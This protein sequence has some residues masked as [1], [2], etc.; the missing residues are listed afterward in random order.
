MTTRNTILA[1]ALMVTGGLLGTSLLRADDK[2]PT[3]QPAA[4]Q[5]MAN[6]ANTK[7]PVSGDPIDPAV[8]TTYD[9][10]TYAFCCADCIKS[11][12]KDPAKYAAKAK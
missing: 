4:T 9:G 5:P 3:T 8:T 1:A 10:K 7:C 11:F 2:V 6:A 12:Q